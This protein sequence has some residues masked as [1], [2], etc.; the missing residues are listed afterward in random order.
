MFAAKPDPSHIIPGAEAFNIMYG[1]ATKLFTQFGDKA[2]MP[3]RQRNL[4]VPTLVVFLTCVATLSSVQA[5]GLRINEIQVAENLL[6]DGSLEPWVEFVNIGVSE[7]RLDEFVLRTDSSTWQMPA[8]A[9]APGEF[10]VVHAPVAIDSPG[11]QFLAGDVT[12]VALVDAISN[13]VVDRI[14]LPMATPGESVGRYPD[15][16]GSFQVYGEGDISYASPNRDVGFVSKLASKTEFMPRDS[17][18]NAIV[19]QN[20]YFWILG[21]WGNFA[22]DRW[23]SVSDVWRSKDLKRWQ[24][25]NDS[26]PYFPYNCFIS[27]KGRIWS[28]GEQSHSTSNGRAWRNESSAPCRR[29]VKFR[30]GIVALTG[31]AVTTTVD[32]VH[33]NT[34]T[35]SAP[36]GAARAEPW[37]VVHRDRLWVIGGY[38]GYN[39]PE[40][41]LYNDVWSSPDGVT[42]ELVKESAEWKPRR[43]AAATVYDNKIFLI[44]GANPA[45]WPEEYG[46]TSEV[47]FSS[48]G[49]DWMELKSERQWPARH[50]AFVATG[51]QRD[52]AVLAGYGHGGA[53][54]LYND[55]WSLRT[56]MYFSKPGGDLHR[57]SSWG[58]NMDGS[59]TRPRSFSADH[60]VFVLR[61]RQGFTVDERLSV[62]G[63]GSRILVGDGNLKRP[64][65]LEL[66]NA[67]PVSQPL[68]LYANS[69]TI[70]NGHLPEVLYQDDQATLILE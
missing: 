18:P 27:W 62:S 45:L 21:G 49:T 36:W 44:G 70:V 63:A 3:F 6:P 31:A 51:K 1:D 5:L 26:P 24:L 25:V 48:D 47:W 29:A 58:R 42:W 64:V 30:N 38:S 9:V 54:R 57:L 56:T 20:G 33:W 66:R 39:T 43:W 16:T 14:T 65:R 23:Y 61:N 22:D 41:V 53:S 17:S 50:A 52:L 19:S 15:G 40:E 13:A 11:A 46:N 2:M 32:G 35:T 4:I 37:L 8:E 12:E 69:T 28:F 67:M 55:S 68:Y 59:G 7:V 60:Q 10:R 34:L